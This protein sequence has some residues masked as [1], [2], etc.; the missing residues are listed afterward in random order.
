ML[1]FAHAPGLSL[2]LLAGYISTALVNN[3]TSNLPLVVSGKSDFSFD[4][5]DGEVIRTLRIEFERRLIRRL[6]H[7]LVA[8][9]ENR[10]FEGWSHFILANIGIIE[11][12]I[13][14]RRRS[15]SCSGRPSR[16]S[17]GWI[18]EPLQHRHR[19]GVLRIQ[20]E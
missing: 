17:R 6:G 13:R 18:L 4:D 8:F 5:L 14:S 3:Q 19:A 16:H 15:A 10:R 2:S 11:L 7:Q 12:R 1:C 9:L 20:F